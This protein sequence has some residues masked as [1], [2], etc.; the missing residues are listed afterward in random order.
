MVKNI[1]SGI[2]SF[3]S[4]A[5]IWLYIIVKYCGVIICASREPEGGGGLAS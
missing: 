4:S 3:G 1:R 2:S 5:I